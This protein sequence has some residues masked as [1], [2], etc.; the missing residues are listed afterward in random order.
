MIL[1][2][3]L[4]RFFKAFRGDVAPAL[5]LLSTILG[6][7][8][9]MIPGFYGIHVAL[10]VLA[11]IININIGIFVLFAFFGKAFCF[12]AA[13]LMFHAGHWAQDH[14]GSFLTFLGSIP[15][16]GVTDFSRYAVAGGV[17]LGPLL[18]LATGTLLMVSVVRFRKA[19][20]ALDTNSERFRVWHSNGWVRLLERILI[21]KRADPAEVLKR[22]ARYVRIPG[23]VAAIAVVILAA[24]GLRFVQNDIVADFAARSMTNVNGAQVDLAGV[25]L[26]PL[27]GKFGVR[28]VQMTDPAR[29][30]ANRV[31][32]GELS[33]E[34]SLLSLTLG[35]I[36]MED[37]KLSNVRFDE[38][39]V[40]A[41]NVLPAAPA[42]PSEPFDINRFKVSE[43]DL[44]KLDSYVN[45]AKSLREWLE[46]IKPWLP[47]R[48]AS[49]PPPTVPHGYLEYLTAC[50]PQ[51]P[52]PHFLIRQ[53][54]LEGVKLPI[55]QIGM[56]TIQCKNLSDAP[57]G[58]GLPITI[59]I[60]STEH[61]CTISV[62]GH[63]EQ[64]AGAAEIK[65]DFA[66]VDLQKLQGQLNK[67]NPVQF[68]G[69]TVSGSIQGS[70]SR[71][72]IDLA[73]RVKT[74][75][76]RAQ[77]SDRGIFGLDP[78]VTAEALKVLENI[79]TTLRLVGPLSEPRL[80]FDGPGLTKEFRDALVRAGKAELANRADKLIGGRLPTGVPSV[81][82]VVDDPLKAGKNLL[83]GLTSQPASLGGGKKKP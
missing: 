31:A 70:A 5:I 21:G 72:S 22:R 18:G 55:E 36:V 82:K 52:T 13:P 45:D 7:S 15:I 39:R 28:G 64:N 54:S 24:V 32:V 63:Y 33:A 56:S 78:Q 14:L 29:P 69:G 26:A 65:A 83:G 20:L 62:I 35:R 27:A 12:A 42:T 17:V 38:A 46:K 6:F 60:K 53:L 23:V 10:L 67:G 66:D 3:S 16:A 30:T 40:K 73:I 8:F 25:S 2:G 49:L 51:C 1:P 43:A 19:W 37:I 71:E 75:G 9:G 41:G 59:D 61:P 81:G 68:Q 48:K 74:K 34:V 57:S 4:R 50:A 47:E 79:E 80:V 77:T 11:L 44:A 58:A 76:M